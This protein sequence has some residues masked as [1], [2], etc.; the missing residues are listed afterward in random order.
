M[1]ELN[2]LLGIQT[3]P[4]TAF[5]PQTDGQTERVNQELEQYLRLYV[6]TRQD[7]WAEWLASFEFAY[8][9]HQHSTTRQTPFELDNGQHPR[10]GI[11][12]RRQTRLEEAGQF[13]ERMEKSLDKAQAA[14]ERGAEDMKRF[15]DRHHGEAPEYK[16]GDRVWLDAINIK[17]TRPMKKLDDRWFG[18]FEITDV[19]SRSAVRLK[20]PHSFQ[21]LHPVFNVVLL[22]EKRGGR[23]GGCWICAV[24]H[25][26]HQHL[27]RN[28]SLPSSPPISWRHLYSAI[29]DLVTVRARYQRGHQL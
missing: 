13:A 11:E 26:L 12:P 21:R 29:L 4:S 25:S 28:S 19:I 9:N 8:N 6:N 2:R 16:K 1:R 17:T 27:R 10:M 24:C 7:D 3:R 23:Y 20:L 15:Y 14:M 18:P 5:H 22:L